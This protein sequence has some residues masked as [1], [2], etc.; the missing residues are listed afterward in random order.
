MKSLIVPPPAESL[1]ACLP[2]VASK[3]ESNR[4]LILR[5]LAGADKIELENLSAARDTCLLES[6]LVSDA[7]VLD[8]QDAGTT[9]RFLTAWCVAANRPALITGSP[10]MQERPIGILV[11]AL[12]DLGA[13]IDYVKNEGFCPLKIHGFQQSSRKVSMRGDVSSQYVSALLLI[14]SFLEQGIELTLTGEIASRPYID[15]TIQWMARFGL[16]VQEQGQTFTVEPQSPVPGRYAIE[17]DWSA[18]GYWYSLM[19]LRGE[20]KLKLMYLRDKSLQGDRQLA[21]LFVDLGVSSAFV[22]DGVILRPGPRKEKFE[23]DF[24]HISDQAQTF[25]VCCA[26]LGIP[27]KLTGLPSLRIKE[28]DRIA[29]IQNELAKFGCKVEVIGDEAMVLSGQKI[30]VGG[31]R[32]ETYDDHR[33]AM[34]FAPLAALGELTIEEPGVVAKSYPSFWEDWGKVT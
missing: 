31:Q 13:D 25:A 19:A 34:A 18:A 20:G 12:K 8:P 3:S 27:A 15:M 6:L 4:A 2:M 21:D 9:T 24:L 32:V 16:K 22:E 5:A 14:A 7:E 33:M 26:G 28:T 17:S 1:N 29:A 23:A 11:E 30:E 10:R